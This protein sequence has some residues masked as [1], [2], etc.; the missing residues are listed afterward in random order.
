LKK[1]CLRFVPVY[2]QVG[3]R[4][5]VYLLF[6]AVFLAVLV[7]SKFSLHLKKCFCAEKFSPSEVEFFVDEKNSA[8]IYSG[9]RNK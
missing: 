4:F 3:F 9:C 6:S 5:C 2:L 1:R 7:K 8:T